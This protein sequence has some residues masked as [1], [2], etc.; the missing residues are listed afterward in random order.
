MIARN[1]PPQSQ[2]LTCVSQSQIKSLGGIQQIVISHPH[3][4]TTHLEWA[5][6]FECPVYTSV[7][8]KSWLNRSDPSGYRHHIEAP[9]QSFPGNTTAIKAGG[10]FDGSLLLHWKDHL[11]T[12]DTVST[13]QVCMILSKSLPILPLSCFD[14]DEPK[15]A[16]YNPKVKTR[17]VPSYAFL[18]SIPNSTPLPPDKI[19]AIWKAIEPFDFVYTHSVMRMSSIRGIDLKARILESARIQI[20]AEGY[21]D[22]PFLAEGV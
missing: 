17:G 6:A 16:A 18:Y 8:D 19:I 7:D 14:I 2:K 1:G 11:F 3:F 22:H 10:H 15:K 13:V 9:T 21:V 12:A 20:R 5:A 4:Y